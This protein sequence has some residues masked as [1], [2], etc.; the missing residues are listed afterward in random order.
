MELFMELSGE[1]VALREMRKHLA[2]YAKG[3]ANASQFRDK[4]NRIEGKE[5]LI[6]AMRDF[7]SR[8]AP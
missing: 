8:G 2:W 1:R 5:A 7:F 3:L 4:I 6:G